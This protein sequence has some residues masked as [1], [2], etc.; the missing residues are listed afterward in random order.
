[1]YIQY[2]AYI[3]GSRITPLFDE[4][5]V[6]I[7]QEIIAIP[8]DCQRRF[9]EQNSIFNETV[10]TINL[11]FVVCMQYACIERFYEYLFFPYQ[12]S[13]LSVKY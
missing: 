11:S 8:V 2:A 7:L 1:M 10:L 13:V 12:F 9:H 3:S 5:Q 6:S 4:I